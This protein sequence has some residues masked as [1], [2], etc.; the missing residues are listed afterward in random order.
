MDKDVEPV[1]STCLRPLSVGDIIAWVIDSIDED[2]EGMGL[3]PIHLYEEDCEEGERG[4][5]QPF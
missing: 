1:C 3:L 2:G 5:R 4:D